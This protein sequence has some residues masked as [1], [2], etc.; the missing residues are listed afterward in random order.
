VWLS[1][2]C[3]KVIGNL[4]TPGVPLM[5]HNFI[6]EYLLLGSKGATLIK[7]KVPSIQIHP[8][9]P[10]NECNCLH[11]YMN[12][13]RYCCVWEWPYLCLFFGKKC[14]SSLI[15]LINIIICYKYSIAWIITLTKKTIIQVSINTT[16]S[17]EILSLCFEVWRRRRG[18]YELWGGENREKKLKS[19]HIFVE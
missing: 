18:G 14:Y 7:D 3:H 8:Y 2:M 17:T 4:A 6:G 15:K 19:F 1:H 12:V 11:Q 13:G 16:N 5:C 10:W 9:R